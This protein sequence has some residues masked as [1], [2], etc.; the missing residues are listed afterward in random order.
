MTVATRLQ[1]STLPALVGLVSVALLAW[2]G[3]YQ[4]EA[5]EVLVVLVAVTAVSTSLLAWYNA[6]LLARRVREVS[7]GFRALDLTQHA[8]TA[9]GDE[10]DELDRIRDAVQTI[11]AAE[12]GQRA[13]VAERVLAA[14]RRVAE[15]ETLLG[16]VC[17]DVQKRLEETRLALHILQTSPFGELNE[18]QDELVAAARAAAEQ[19]NDELHTLSRLAA[20][21]GT[22]AALSQ[23]RTAVRTLLEV[24]L[25]MAFG[26]ASEVDSRVRVSISAEVPPVS[27][28][29]TAA[30][31]ALAVLCRVA[32]D[33]LSPGESLT[34]DVTGGDATV[35]VTVAP[36]PAVVEPMP[37]RVALA[38]RAL[39]GTT[40]KVEVGGGQLI[41][42]L[43]PLP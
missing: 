25:A 14:D 38:L 30:H 36:F 13:V 4:R 5:P 18:N 6:R 17:A 12:L 37:I 29:L 35:I 3:E 42:H 16:T 32:A 11:V 43:R 1:L 9:G 8:A 21:S 34:V 19:A 31:E 15:Y 7:V 41:L 22:V 27:V 20:L 40:A 10:L 26:G 28:A 2:F 33:A 39:H 24:P 23:Q